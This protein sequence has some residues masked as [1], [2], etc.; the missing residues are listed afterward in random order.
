MLGSWELGAWELG[1]RRRSGTPSKAAAGGSS[2]GSSSGIDPA[3]RRSRP[4][5]LEIWSVAKLF[6]GGEQKPGDH[7][8]AR[9]PF[10]Q[11]ALGSLFESP[12]GSALIGQCRSPKAAAN[13]CLSAS[14]SLTSLSQTLV[15]QRP[16]ND[17]VRPRRT[18]CAVGPS[19]S[20][21]LQSPSLQAG[22]RQPVPVLP[23]ARFPQLETPSPSPGLLAANKVVAQLESVG[24]S[25]LSV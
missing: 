2:N 23:A 17:L 18:H 1:S 16:T 4:S 9:R 15:L 25:Q 8:R 19:R 10:R 3:L 12:A 13:I 5:G 14:R 7:W 24:P 11:G 6:G 20:P 21:S 22:H